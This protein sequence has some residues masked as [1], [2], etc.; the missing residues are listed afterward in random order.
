M[1]LKQ[2][3]VAHV[4]LDGGGVV[5][6]VEEGVDDLLGGS[7]GGGGQLGDASLGDLGVGLEEKGLR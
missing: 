1:G 7:L 5:G 2:G 6:L 3:T 4:G